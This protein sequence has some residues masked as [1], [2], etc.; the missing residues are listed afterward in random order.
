MADLHNVDPHANGLGDLGRPDGFAKRQVDGWA[1]R[2]E[3]AK[4]KDVPLFY[5][6]HRR[7]EAS[8]PSPQRVSV[9]HND[10]KFDNCQFQPENPDR[11]TSIFDWDMATLGDPLID[12]GTLRGYWSEATDPAPRGARPIGATRCVSDACGNHPAI[13]RCRPA[14]TSAVSTGT[15]RSR[16]GK[17]RWSCSRSTS[18]MRAAR[19]KDERFARIAERAPLLLEAAARLEF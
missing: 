17:R 15:K 3:L 1:A 7:L 19:R 2:W 11:V 10:L 5:E 8:V 12:L 4:D 13:C 6:V 18:D 16:C 9:L 14:S